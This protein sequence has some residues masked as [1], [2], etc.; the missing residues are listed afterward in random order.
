M[1]CM[2]CAFK[3]WQP[4]VREDVAAAVGTDDF[5]L[6]NL[7]LQRYDRTTIRRIGAGPVAHAFAS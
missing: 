1:A 2:S 3:D 4:Q 6:N 5:A 7:G